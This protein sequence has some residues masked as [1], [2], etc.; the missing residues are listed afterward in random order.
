[1]AKV[2]GVWKSS[3][4]CPD[5]TE[6]HVKYLKKIYEVCQSPSGHVISLIASQV[7]HLEEKNSNNM[8]N[9]VS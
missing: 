2:L 6:Q 7:S 8:S 9:L 1:M 3:E 5:L 4:D